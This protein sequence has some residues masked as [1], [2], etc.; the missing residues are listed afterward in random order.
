MRRLA[1]CSAILSLA[2]CGKSGAITLYGFDTGADATTHT[3]APTGTIS[4][5]S[6]TIDLSNSGWKY[7]VNFVAGNPVSGTAIGPHA[8]IT[9][10]HVAPTPGT[11]VSYGD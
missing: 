11:V 8:F 5:N 10:G 7:Q 2:I 9:A 6:Q 1:R 4:Y 3:T